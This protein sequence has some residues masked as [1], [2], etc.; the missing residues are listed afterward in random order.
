M[1]QSLYDN[2]SVRRQDRL[3]EMDRTEE[4]LAT[5]GYGV[6]S[7]VDESGEAYG[8]PL[9]FVW[10]GE[11]AIYIHCAQ[12]GKKLRAISHN[13]DVSFCIVGNVLPRPERLT[14]LYESL[15]IKGKAHIGLPSE[16]RHEALRLLVQKFAP[17]QIAHGELSIE[18]SFYRTEIIRIDIERISAKSK[19][20]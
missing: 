8:V 4:L 5:A 6:L 7:M 11:S 14:T 1:I 12:E 10:N 19:W 13:A 15:I 16:E 20:P 9:N 3:L 18:K 2:S 17:D